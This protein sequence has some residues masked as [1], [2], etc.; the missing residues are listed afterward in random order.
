[1]LAEST[2]VMTSPSV[3]AS[4]QLWMPRAACPRDIGPLAQPPS[5]SRTPLPHHGAFRF[6]GSSTSH[7]P[8]TPSPREVL[9]SVGHDWM[10][11][12][13]PLAAHRDL[14]AHADPGPR[15]CR[16]RAGRAPRP[17]L[18]FPDCSQS[19]WSQGC[20]QRSVDASD[21][22]S[23]PESLTK[24]ARPICR[25]ACK[26]STAVLH[27]TVETGNNR[28]ACQQGTDLHKL[29]TNIMEAT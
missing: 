25:G 9:L 20:G 3:L 6:S 2:E 15:N 24:E 13:R 10:L 28:N 4:P 19:S 14:R 27:L 16:S 11:Q 1:M 18:L 29:H 22:A 17:P 7:H 5:S 26:E 8:G 12:S 23:F 21:L